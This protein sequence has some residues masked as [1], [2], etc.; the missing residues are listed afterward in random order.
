MSQGQTKKKKMDK[1]NIQFFQANRLD[2]C[3]HMTQN[4]G[5]AAKLRMTSSEKV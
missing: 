4:I 1:N 2:F 5:T 3:M